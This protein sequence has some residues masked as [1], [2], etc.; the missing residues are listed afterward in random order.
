MTSIY[1]SDAGIIQ[2]H[3]NITPLKVKLIIHHQ[4]P[5]VELVSPL[6]TGYGAMCHLPPDRRVD[7]G[8]ITQ[9]GFCFNPSRYMSAGV[10]MYKLQRKNIDQSNE[11][12]ISSEEEA[13][14]IRLV[15][16]WKIEDYKEFSVASYLLERNESCF[17]DMDRPQKLGKHYEL[18][19]IQN[20]T[21]EETWLMHNNTVLMTS[22]D[23]LHE[24]EGYKLEMT[25]SEASMKDDTQRLR[26][27]NVLW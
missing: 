23:V 27:T 15:I 2:S 10:L 13:T 20:G 6:Y 25:M 18:V 11:N 26:Y 9:V 22:L 7:V 21:I 4:L 3:Q 19:N 5:G 8:S 12:S 24:G 17:W 1:A 16:L 14:C